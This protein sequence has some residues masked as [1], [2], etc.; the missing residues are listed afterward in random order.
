MVKKIT[1]TLTVFIAISING[2]AWVYPEHRDITLSA[3][4]KLDSA[5]RSL[6][7]QL[8]TMARKGHELRLTELVADFPQGEHPKYIDYAAW[9]AIGGDHS[10][11]P[12]NLLHNV[13]ETG[14]IMNVADV[15]AR[16][17]VGI[18]TSHNRSER[19][20]RLRDS[21]IR[22]L[23]ADP[24][25][26]SRA[27][28][29]NGHF[30]LARPEVGTLPD[31]YFDSCSREGCPLN[32]IGTY[33]WFHA[34]ALLK[35]R[36]LAT[37]TL[38]PGQRSALALAALADEAFAM[39]FLEDGFASGHVAG[40]WGDASQRKG[41]HDYYNEKGLE[42]T[43]WKG[44]RIVII[45]DAYMQPEDANRAANTVSASLYQFL[46]AASGKF[47]KQLINDQPG[48]MT[49]DTFNVGKAVYMP[50][51]D[52][53]TTFGILFYA[54]LITTPVPGLAT[55]L[56]EIPRFR[57]EIG[58][59]IGLAASARASVVSS[60]FEQSQATSGFVPGLGLAI[61]IGLGMEG[62][63]NESGDGLAFLDIGWRL[64]GASSM[65]YYNEPSLKYFGSMLSAIPSRDGYFARLRLP[66]CLI[67]GDLL[68]A[69]P[70]LL[71]FSPGTLN[72]MIV[73][74]GNGGLIPWQ[75][76]MV[77][78][79]GRFQFIIG[80]E[81][82]ACFYGVDKGGDAML[83]PDNSVAADET[84]LVSLYSMQLDFPILEYRPFRTF[85]SRQGADLVIQ[86]N[87]GADF[88]ITTTVVSEVTTPPQMKTIWF[89]GLRMAFDW[90]YYFSS[91]K[92]R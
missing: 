89:I 69:A 45:G 86:L 13:L 49:A 56:G 8:W 57:S 63:L 1:L 85:S 20:N 61:R 30:M 72:K 62:V 33:K 73:A 83:I 21:D 65:K 36:R 79:I 34:S 29:N 92:N 59:F 60:G 84:L 44:D 38:T 40:I 75:S 47:D 3:I 12:A 82:G 22:L 27:G 42:V 7:Q 70:F 16:L 6:L 24:E 46:D 66:F 78:P 32:L 11:S 90:R 81:I 19:T 88:P 10:T 25:Y 14:W 80:R 64:D 41:T 55:G 52:L 26:V 43:T 68:I 50:R 87:A 71:L 39:H 28:A 76:G 35:A 23:R 58:P 54:V 74:A 17:K 77:T 91:K 9:P 18:E 51:R 5:H 53:D 2:H 67:P 37:E 15:A 31:A 4:Q 48:M